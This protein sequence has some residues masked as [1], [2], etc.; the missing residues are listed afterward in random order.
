M[1]T[2]YDSD[3]EQDIW[4]W[5]DR[6]GHVL[7]RNDG[8][9]LT[10]VTDRADEVEIGNPMGIDGADV[11]LD[12][13]LDYYIS[14]IGDHPLLRNEGDGTFTNVTR[15]AGTRGDYGWGLGF[16]DFDLDG[17]TDL[18][19]AQEDN[20]PFLLFHHRGG[21]PARFDERPVEHIDT[22]NNRAAH[23]M[24]VAFADYDRD[25]DM[26]VA[27]AGTDRR[28]LMLYR[29]DTDHGS[30]RWLKVRIGEVPARGGVGGV[31]ARVV[32]KTGDRIQFE[33]ISGGSSRASQTELVARFG[34]GHWTGATWVA[35]LWPDGRQYA[36]R[37]VEGNRELLLPVR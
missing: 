35:V 29:N 10:D 28:P 9:V 12:G 15:D 34:L 1:W 17:W 19:V 30:H 25:G 21:S 13:D 18:F 11:D 6:G 3:G 23:N 32:V 2:D 27:V 24:P 5:N 22:V 8:G 16:E 33:D 26:D 37:G 14:N 4:I 31:T 20:R 36:V 7:L